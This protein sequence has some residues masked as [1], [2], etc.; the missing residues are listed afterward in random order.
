MHILKKYTVIL[1]IH[2]FA[3]YGFSACDQSE[4][5]DTTWKTH[6]FFNCTPFWIA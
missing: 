3:F 1:L 6:K 2:G 4:F 5:K